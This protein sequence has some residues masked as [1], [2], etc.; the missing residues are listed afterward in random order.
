[1]ETDSITS[2]VTDRNAGKQGVNWTDV[3]LF[4]VLAFGISWLIWIGLRAIGVPFTIRASIGMFGPALAAVLVRLLRKEG[5]ADA[6]L[7]LVGKGYRGGGWMYLAAYLAV[8]L[9]IGAGILLSLLWA[10][11]IG[12]LRRIYRRAHRRLPVRCTSRAQRCQRA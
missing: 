2:D 7:R 11:S 5:F 1:M 4:I 12:L 8:P 9:L 6:G 10:I 3:V